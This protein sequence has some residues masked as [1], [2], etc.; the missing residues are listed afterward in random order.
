MLKIISYGILF[1]IIYF[2]FRIISVFLKVPNKNDQEIKTKSK[3]NINKKDIIDA[4]FK[5][6]KEDDSK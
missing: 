3:L 1:F 4:E 5:E 6:I 2:L